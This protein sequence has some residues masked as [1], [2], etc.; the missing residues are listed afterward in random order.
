MIYITKLKHNKKSLKNRLFFMSVKKNTNAKIKDF[1]VYS[2]YFVK[3]T[4]AKQKNRAA[5]DLLNIVVILCFFI[6]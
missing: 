3:Q 2:F 4:D 5:S 6:F 1:L